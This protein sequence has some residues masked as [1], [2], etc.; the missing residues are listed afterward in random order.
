MT[1]PHH[2]SAGVAATLIALA[3]LPA[4]AAAEASSS[5]TAPPAADAPSPSV[6]EIIVTARKRAERLSEV[7]MSITAVAEAEESSSMTAPPAA[8]APSPSVG[9]IIVT[10][11]KRAE[12]LSEVGM[13]ITAVAEAELVE[14]GITAPA[15]LTRIEPSLQFTP[16]P[17]GT[18][19]YTIRGVGY[20]EQSL[21]ATPA[22]SLYQDE[23]PYLY[24]VFAKGALL[25][26][27]HVEIL[28]GPQ[29][30]LFGQNVTG[31]A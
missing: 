6:G 15:G 2:A 7:G 23:T 4:Q 10:A 9:E 24:P 29:G 1:G 21:A 11:R 31:G 28:K 26:V 20:F 25:D 14:K 27:D 16:S 19:I 17:T 18:P 12:R 8:D 3:G 5:M 13:S 30:I 22:V